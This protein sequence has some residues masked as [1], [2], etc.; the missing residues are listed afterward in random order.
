MKTLGKV[1]KARRTMYGETHRS[2]EKAT[3]VNYV[4]IS[5]IETG[6]NKNPSFKKIAALAKFLDFSLDDLAKHV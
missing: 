1:L 5:Q 2:V 4:T 6:A 3:G